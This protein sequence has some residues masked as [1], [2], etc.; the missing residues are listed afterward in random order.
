MLLV[1]VEAREIKGKSEGLVKSRRGN[2]R[3]KI[4]GEGGREKERGSEI[5]V[6]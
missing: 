2:I 3:R 4:Q 5:G 6:W 1:A